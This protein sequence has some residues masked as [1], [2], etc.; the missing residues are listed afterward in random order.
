MTTLTQA[1]VVSRLEGV[2][3]PC[4]VATN[5]PLSIVEMGM[6]VHVDVSSGNV[7]VRLRMTSPL[8]HALPYFQMEIERVLA[9]VPGIGEVRCTFDDGASWQPENM[10]AE[11]RRK[12]AERR[13]LVRARATRSESNSP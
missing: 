2:V 6:I 8:C 11:A 10:A 9:D 12:L 1:D 13:E 3:D 4:S 7:V 5:V